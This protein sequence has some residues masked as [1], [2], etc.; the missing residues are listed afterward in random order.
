MV[1]VVRWSGLATEEAGLM[2]GRRRGIYF[3]N[4]SIVRHAIDNRLTHV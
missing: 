3:D 1:V 4:Y 2:K